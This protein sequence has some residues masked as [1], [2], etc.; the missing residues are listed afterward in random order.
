[1]RIG[2][3]IG[4]VAVLAIA[5]SSSGRPSAG[6]A[7]APRGVTV[8]GGTSE[9]RE[10][11]HWAVGQFDAAGLELPSIE[12]RF[13]ADARGC[14]G[15]LGY[16]RGGIVDVC[17]TLVNA[18]SRRIVLHEL[19]HA[20]AAVNVTGADRARFLRLRGLDELERRQ[21]P[22]EPAGVRARGRDH[23]LGDRGAD[24]VA[25]AAGHRP[26]RSSR[27]RTGRSRACTLP[28]GR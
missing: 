17:S 23:R 5:L 1:M 15:H 26:R 6:Q 21:R 3:W 7:S 4:T 24:L 2:R 12:I 10:L 16:S 11:A 14:G 9:Q 18:M 20:W 19:A 13:H 25:D 8:L 22:V 27:R 28:A